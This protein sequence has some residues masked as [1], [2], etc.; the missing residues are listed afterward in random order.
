MPSH[1]GWIK[2]DSGQGHPNKR[3]K[4]FRK[5]RRIL[6]TATASRQD[7]VK[8]AS[9]AFNCLECPEATRSSINSYRTISR[10]ML[11]CWTGSQGR[12]P[13]NDFK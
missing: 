12:D 3:I 2:P 7:L 9:L 1:F 6:R 4:G 5:V 10:L 13:V 11:P 8:R